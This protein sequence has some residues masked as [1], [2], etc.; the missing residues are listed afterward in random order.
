MLRKTLDFENDIQ[1]SQY[2]NYRNYLTH[3]IKITKESYYKNQVTMAGHDQKKIWNIFRDATNQNNSRKEKNICIK[4]NGQSITDSKEQADIFN[5][6]FVDI[7][8]KMQEK[9]DVPK[10]PPQNIL[11]T[12]NC[13]PQSC[14]YFPVNEEEVKKEIMTLKNNCATGPDGISSEI[15]KKIGTQISPPIVHL[16]NTMF[17][18][19]IF[20]QSLKTSLISPV[21]KA[22]AKDNINNYRPISVIGNIAKVVEKCLKAR[23]VVFLEKHNIISKQ[24]FGFMKGKSTSDAICDLVK[25][26]TNSLNC[27][28][29]CIAVF[30]DLA[31]AFDTVPHDRLIYKLRK[32]GFRGK[33]GDLLSSYLNNRYQKVRIGQAESSYLGVKVGIPQGTVLGPILFLLYVNDLFNLQIDGKFISYAD[34]TAVLFR[35]SNLGTV[36]CSVGKGLAQIKEW[37]RVNLLTLNLS[38][39]RYIH[40]N[41]TSDANTQQAIKIH[42]TLCKDERSCNCE[43]IE[44]VSHIKYLGVMVDEAL[45][46]KEHV[47]MLANKLRRLLPTFFQIRNIYTSSLKKSL[48]YALVESN[49]RYGII[50]WGSAYSNAVLPLEI[51][52][53]TLIKVLYVKNRLYSTERLFAE[54][55][56]LTIRNLYYH[57]SLSYIHSHTSL[58]ECVAPTHGTRIQ[59]RK[60]FKLMAPTKEIVKRTLG[61]TGLKKY[62]HLPIELIN[63]INM[64]KFKLLLRKHILDHTE[65]YDSI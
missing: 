36:Q 3:L 21:F 59:L 23:I 2:K 33:A 37:L 43:E 28:E 64:S 53:R 1:I 18:T 13:N 52:Q 6:H 61:Y 55:G 16:I 12:Q 62:N 29:K 39:T 41:M 56:L 48:Y 32:Y 15:L 17:T 45:K 14:F 44:K 27:D 58:F 9:I 31:K 65:S 5:K 8:L 20:P 63:T 25:T 35:G 57:E 10:N 54:T 7:G 26:V 34:D 19:A 38:K 11:T 46:W 47:N 51:L 30:L 50:T 60:E 42:D 49:I 22:K 40:F 24:Q 4:T